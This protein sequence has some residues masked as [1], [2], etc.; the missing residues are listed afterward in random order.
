VAAKP[1]QVILEALQ[2]FGATVATK[3]KGL[4]AGEPEDQLRAPLETFLTEVGKVIGHSVVPK[5]E[6][7]LAGRLGRPDYAVLVDKLLAGYIELKAPGKG[8]NPEHYKAADRGQWKRFQCLPN[9][10][11]SD[12]NEWALY[13]DGKRVGQLVRL[14]GD[15]TKS[16]AAAV[17][18]ADVYG[19]KPLLIDFLGWDPIVPRQ[20]SA[21]AE[22]LA[23]L[24]RMLR[25]EVKDALKSPN[26][27]LVQLAKDWRQLLFPEADD[28]RFADAYATD[29]NLR[30]LA[31][32]V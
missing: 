7:L 5:G 30:A 17:K 32:T 28:D 22:L 4:A 31:R 12:G 27:A 9:L 26:A 23:P 18:P 2:Q 29:G 1:D 25:E 8:A 11:Y 14:S 10:I 19:L 6:S 13:R 15:V 21:L 20:A 3:I 24:C 16:G